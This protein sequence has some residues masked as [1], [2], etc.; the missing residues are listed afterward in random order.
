MPLD[1]VS[2]SSKDKRVAQQLLAYVTT[3]SSCYIFYW[4]AEDINSFD[5]TEAP[6]SPERADKIRSLLQKNA[7]NMQRSGDKYLLDWNNSLI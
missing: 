4:S 2:L 1:V 7:S 3:N 6:N 5:L